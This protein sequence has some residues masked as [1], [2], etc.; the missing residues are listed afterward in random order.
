MKIAL[1]QGLSKENLETRHNFLGGSDANTLL[2]GTPTQVYDLWLE[3]I[4]EKAPDD[5]S[6]VLP[7]QMGVQSEPLNVKWF[8]HET[9]HSVLLEDKP[10]VSTEIPFMRATLDGW[11]PEQQAVL[12]CKHVNQFSKIDE[13]VQKYMPQLHHNMIVCECEKAFLSVFIGT[14]TYELVEVPLEEFYAASLLKRE[15]DFWK[16]VQDRVAPEGFEP[17]EA[18]AAPTE[19][20]TVDMQGH[21]EWASHASDWLLNKDAAKTFDASAKALKGL[22]EPNCGH[23]HGHGVEIKRA[24]NGSLRIGEEK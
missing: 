24:K 8:A 16:C 14:V 5:L 19:F 17:V 9:G 3:K 6:W 1:E 23:A 12:E 10:R 22:M 4:G 15:R 18:P 7:V 21:N 20:I 2:N 11:V 13:V